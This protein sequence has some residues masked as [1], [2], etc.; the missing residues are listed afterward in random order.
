MGRSVAAAAVVAV[1]A[2]GLLTHGA[3]APFNPS[4]SS[5]GSWDGVADPS[6][7][8]PASVV[9]LGV[10]ASFAI[11]AESLPQPHVIALSLRSRER[12]PPSG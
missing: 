2:A 3:P 6:G 9:V 8:P 7:P 10:I 5:V 4:S 12:G 11:V 1:L